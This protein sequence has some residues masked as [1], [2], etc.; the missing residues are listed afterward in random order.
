MVVTGYGQVP[1]GR[2]APAPPARPSQALT[3]VNPRAT[4]CDRVATTL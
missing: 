3:A 4:L 1:P 2:A